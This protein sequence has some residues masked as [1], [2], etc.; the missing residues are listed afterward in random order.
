MYQTY[1]QRLLEDINDIP[2][3]MLPKLYKIVHLLKKE[4]ISTPKE[5]GKRSSLK[6]IW[7]NN[8]VDEHLLDEARKS[9]FC[10]EKE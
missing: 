4:L 1:K 5:G 6:G 2:A 9:L 7:K 3:D 10:Y 8:D